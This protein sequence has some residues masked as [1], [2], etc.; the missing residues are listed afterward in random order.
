MIEFLKLGKQQENKKKT[1]FLTKVNLVN[2]RSKNKFAK[3]TIKK[4]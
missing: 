1:K 4:L 3:V 2:G